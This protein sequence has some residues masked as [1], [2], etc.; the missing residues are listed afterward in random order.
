MINI[1]DKFKTKRK[2]FVPK[3]MSVLK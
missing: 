1:S 2:F 3:T